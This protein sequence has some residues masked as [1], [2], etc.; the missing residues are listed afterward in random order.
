MPLHDRLNKCNKLYPRWEGFWMPE[1]ALS[2]EC[3]IS[4]LYMHLCK[5]T[6]ALRMGGVH[7][8]S[9]L[10]QFTHTTWSNIHWVKQLMKQ[11]PLGR[12]GVTTGGNL[13]SSN[14]KHFPPIFSSFLST[15]LSPSFSVTCSI[16]SLHWL[17]PG[18]AWGPGHSGPLLSYVLLYLF[19]IL[20]FLAHPI[21]RESADLSFFVFFNLGY[22][23][24]SPGKAML[25]SPSSHI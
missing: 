8:S 15:S 4:D 13:A 22:Q 16:S 21:W 12:Y 14:I 17:N 9:Y 18:S 10:L 7:T 24:A 25:R 6:T 3:I 11:V 2:R 5:K 23:L 1:R 20:Y 19:I